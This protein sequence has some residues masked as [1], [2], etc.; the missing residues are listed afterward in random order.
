[1]ALS[2][3]TDGALTGSSSSL[4]VVTASVSVPAGHMA[5]FSVAAARNT[6][7]LPGGDIATP[8][9]LAGL[10]WSDITSVEWGSRRGSRVFWAK[11]ETGSTV[12]GAISCVISSGATLQEAMWSVDL[13]SSPATGAPFGTGGTASGNAASISISVPGTPAAGDKVFAFIA[14]ESATNAITLGSEL[15]TTLVQ[16]GSGA[17]VRRILSAYDSAPDG[18]PVANASW[19]GSA[20]HG[21]IAAILFAGPTADTED[22]TQSGSITVDS[23]TD[24]TIT[25]SYPAGSDNVAVTGYEVSSNGGSSYTTIGNVLTHT[26]TGLTASTEYNLRVRAKDAA[27]RVSSPA[28]ALAVTTNAPAPDTTAPTMNGAITVT[29]KTAT[30]YTLNWPA[31]SD[32]VAVTGYEVSLDNQGSWIDVGNVLTYTATGRTNGATDL[33]AVRAYDAASP[34]NKATPL[35]LSVLV[36]VVPSTVTVNCLRFTEGSNQRMR[37]ALPP[38]RTSVTILWRERRQVQDIYSGGFVFTK[39]GVNDDFDPSWDVLFTTHGCAGTYDSNGQK[40][41][42]AEV[43]MFHEIAG[44]H[45]PSDGLNGGQ[46]YIASDSALGTQVA[47]P[48]VYDVW[49][50]RAATIKLSGGS[51]VEYI[52]QVDCSDMSKVILQNTL[53]SDL[54][55]PANQYLDFGAPS[56]K[57]TGSEDYRGDVTHIKIFEPL[58]NAEIRQEL[59][60]FSDTPVV[61]KTCWYSNYSPTAADISDKKPSSPAHPFVWHNGTATTITADFETGTTPV[62]TSVT[63]S[64]STHSQVSA[65]AA[66]SYSTHSQVSATAAGSYSTLSQVSATAAGSY[67]THSQVSATATGSYS[68][69]SQVSATAAGSYSTHSQVSATA[70]GSY[71]THSQVS[72]TATGSYSTQSQVSA[73][74]AGSYSTHSQVSATAAGSYSTH[75]QVSATAAGSYNTLGQ[76]SVVTAGT[77]S[78]TH[79]GVLGDT[80]TA[81]TSSGEHGPGFLYPSLRTGDGAKRYTYTITRAPSGTLDADEYG[82]FS[83]T[84]AAS[85]FDVAITEDSVLLGEITVTVA[86]SLTTVVSTFSG[87]YNTWQAVQVS[88]AGSYNLRSVVQALASGSYSTLSQASTTIGGNYATQALVST[89][90]A[91]NYDI[92]SDTNVQATQVGSYDTLA[93]VRGDQSGSYVLLESITK[94]LIDSFDVHQLISNIYIGNYSVGGAPT[95]TGIMYESVWLFEDKTYFGVVDYKYASKIQERK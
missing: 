95:P 71:N 15:D 90:V 75:S 53:L 1:M 50:E 41:A 88:A 36:V 9:G 11:N 45:E 52:N 78:M 64:Y 26:F 7:T 33:T 69:Q 73:T 61:A 37:M 34:A 72:A 68:T 81:L 30:G 91:G 31:A 20:N 40:T 44:L 38:S 80:I 24:T 25:V 85:D 66:G 54:T 10:T 2:H 60:N 48:A 65:T 83:Y 87:G 58:T 28:L 18:T 51:T 32:N 8:T 76:V 42:G 4:T 12:T 62:S 57:S 74:A 79:P 46:D 29:G 94:S 19:S 70:A 23:K 6:G 56:W 27:G 3:L 84:G 92:L 21:G 14:T 16:R 49:V 55:T 59:D 43:G 77:Y 93:E 86:F 89:V 5:I 22:P 47:Y 17:N 39:G 13:E 82:A 35:T 63:G 67:N